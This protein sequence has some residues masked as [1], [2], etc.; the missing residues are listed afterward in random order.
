M[1]ISI[2]IDAPYPSFAVIS[3]ILHWIR[4]GLKASTAEDGSFVLKAT[5]SVI[6]SYLG[7][8]PPPVSAPH[9]YIFVLYEQPEGFDVSKYAPAEG[10][11][12]GMWG[13]IRFDLDGFEK[14]NGLGPLVASNYLLSN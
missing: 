2:D 1:L 4:P 9:R 11:E 3:P 12:F 10:K 8:A 13:R 6:A 7:P 5:A 14:E